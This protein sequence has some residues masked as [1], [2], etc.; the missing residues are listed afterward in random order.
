MPRV[1]GITWTQALCTMHFEI[2]FEQRKQHQ[3]RAKTHAQNV[4]QFSPHAPRHDP[5][6]YGSAIDFIDLS[7][8]FNVACSFDEAFFVGGAVFSSIFENSSLFF[9][10]IMFCSGRLC[11]S[12]VSIIRF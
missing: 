11:V 8:I 10:V 5:A 1:A 6:R 3:T 4:R 12:L 7:T 9:M 2:P